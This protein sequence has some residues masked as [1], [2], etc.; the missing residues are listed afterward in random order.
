[1]GEMADFE[2]DHIEDY[3]E[4]VERGEIEP[5]GLDDNPLFFGGGAPRPKTCRC[6]GTDDLYW[7]SVRFHGAPEAKW[8]LCTEDGRLHRCPPRLERARAVFA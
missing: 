2:L 1:M 7:R 3:Y 6:C 5:E 8:W 4:A